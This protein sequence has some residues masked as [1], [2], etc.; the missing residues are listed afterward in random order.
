MTRLRLPIAA[1]WF[2]ALMLAVAAQGYHHPFAVGANEGA[3]SPSN[4]LTAWI[5][6]QEA[7]FYLPLSNAIRL[8]KSGGGALGLL[9]LSFAYG[10]FHAAGPGHGKAVVSAYVVSNERALRRGFVIAVLAALLQASIAV[11]LVAAAAFI[12][13]ATA[14]R[15]TGAA[16]VLEMASYVG[17]IGLGF[18]LLWRKGGALLA[19][20]RVVPVP[21]VATLGPRLHAG[22]SM[23]FSTVAEPTRFVADD[24]TMDHVHGPSCGHV[25]MPDP[26]QLDRAF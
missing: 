24:C 18:V 4:G 17:I 15:I 6:A 5:I 13:N 10:V 14:A 8:V 12:F 7:R 3:V 22:P 25:H 1:L 11:V 23:R 9:G 16:R 21:A 26:R 20:I 2:A 19:S